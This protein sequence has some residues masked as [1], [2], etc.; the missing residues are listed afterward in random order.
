MESVSKSLKGMPAEKIICLP[1]GLHFGFT[2]PYLNLVSCTA[3]PP[4][5]DSR[6]NCGFVSATRTKTICF[7]S[8]L[9]AA[10]DELSFAVSCLGEVSPS[11]ETIHNWFT[12]LYSHF[13]S[14]SGS[15]VVTV[16]TALL[17]SLFKLSPLMLLICSI[18]VTLTWRFSCAI[19]QC[20]IQEAKQ[21]SRYFFMISSL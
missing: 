8:G 2:A 16:N 17:P 11:V 5:R 9:Q 15:I 3:S 12:Y 1:S 13:T 4:L 21:S 10:C 19:K 7:P 18:S 20:V 6:N 14:P